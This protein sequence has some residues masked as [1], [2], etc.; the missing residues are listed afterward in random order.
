MADE[1]VTK[2]SWMRW[3][4]NCCEACI[5]WQRVPEVHEHHPHLGRCNTDKSL[6]CGDLTD[7]RNRCPAFIRMAGI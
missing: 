7:S 4:P 2:P 6:N 1:T 3:P 5:G